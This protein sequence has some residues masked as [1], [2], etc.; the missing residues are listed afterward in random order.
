[1]TPLLFGPPGRRL[2]GIFH[3]PANG[4]APSSAVLLCP[5]VGQELIRSHRFFR[6]LSDRLAR[7]GVAVLRFDY[8]GTGDSPGEE[9][10]GDLA[11]WQ[12]DVLA[13]HAELR[14][15]A[16]G[17]PIAWCGARLGAT[18]AAAA[19]HAAAAGPRQL[20]LWEPVLD[21]AA[22]LQGLREAHVAMLEQTFYI[23]P[24]GL[25]RRLAAEPEAFADGPLG[26][27][28]SPLL[29]RQLRGLT[30]AGVGLAGSHG[31]CVLA[32]PDDAAARQWVEARAAQGLP[33]VL[34]PL[35]HALAWTEDPQ[36]GNA[37]VP[38]EALQPLLRQ[39]RVQ[40]P[41]RGTPLPEAA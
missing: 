7:S 16:G 19:A 27:E 14:R 31:T 35:L 5:P 36:P 13:A 12:A 20:L 1:M 2:F 15:L 25:R 28:I 38:S 41:A 4:L 3:A 40:A 23:P 8:H 39:L 34:E 37:M 24:R 30:P 6:V 32:K 10:G 22:Y 33:V 11:G 17:A 29:L 21:G 18:L 9:A 26:F